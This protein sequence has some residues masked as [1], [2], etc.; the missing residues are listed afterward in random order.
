M[1]KIEYTKQFQRRLKQ[2][3]SHQPRVLERFRV[4]LKLFSQ[5]VR[6]QPLNDHSLTGKLKGLRAFS[7]GG[8]VRVVYQET[9]DHY[10]FLDIGSHNQ[11]Y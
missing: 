10:L 2:R 7:V 9:E 5:G 4:H 8:D 1:K 3:Y 6:G 11:V